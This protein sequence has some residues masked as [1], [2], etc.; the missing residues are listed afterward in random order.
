MELIEREEF[1]E[2]LSA[3]FTD[4]SAGKGRFVLVSGEAGIGKTSLIES[5]TE[6]H[7][8]DAR[9]LWGACDALFTPRPLGP[10]YDIAPK[11]QTNLL[12]LLQDEAP[13]AS[14]LAAVLQEMDGRTPSIF[15]IE[16]IHWADEATLDLLKF[17]GPR[18]NRVKSMVVATY[19]DDEVGADHPLTLTLGHLPHR[20]IYRLRLPPL[21]EEGVNAMA[22]RAGRRGEDLFVVTAGNPF[23]VTEALASKTS[24]VPNTVRDAVISR[25]HR[26]PS[27]ARAVLELVSIIPARTEMWL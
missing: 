23:F 25:A 9:L 15:V 8:K 10:L 20:S 21:S 7:Q 1:L 12:S 22:A 5:F 24:G 19:R 6:T 17:L 3:A 13:R 27:S 26:L 18:V 11:A 4:V 16:D 2:E 14:I